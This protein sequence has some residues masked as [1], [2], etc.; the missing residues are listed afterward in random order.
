MTVMNIHNFAAN[1]KSAEMFRTTT[2]DI[3]DV[4]SRKVFKDAAQTSV[5]MLMKTFRIFFLPEK[6]ANV[7]GVKSCCTSVKSGAV[8]PIA[9]SSPDVRIGLPRTMT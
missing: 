7:A 9:G 3:A 1:G 8:L 6:L 2:S 5:S 4:R